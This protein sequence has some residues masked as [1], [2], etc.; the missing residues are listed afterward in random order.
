MKLI[1]LR[2][3]LWSATQA[4]FTAV[5]ALASMFKSSTQLRLE[6]IALRQQLTVL[7]RSAP[8]RLKLKPTDGIFWV[9]L[10]FVWT[11]WKSALMIVKAETVIAW[12]RKGFR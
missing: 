6:N 4:L 5:G 7:R 1:D 2:L 8:K 11:D 12:R 9:W 10:R 3:F